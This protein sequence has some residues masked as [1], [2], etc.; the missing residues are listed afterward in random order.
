MVCTFLLAYPL[1]NFSK[2][3]LD[4]YCT[5]CHHYR[6]VQDSDLGKFD[7]HASSLVSNPKCMALYGYFLKANFRNLKNTN[8]IVES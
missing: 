3:D 4:H 7:P 1:E 8:K 5:V 2:I 6:E